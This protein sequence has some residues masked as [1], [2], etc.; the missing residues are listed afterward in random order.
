[1]T[2][3]QLL[4]SREPPP[5]HLSLI[6]GDYRPEGTL[7]HSCPHGT[8][9]SGIHPVRDSGVE[10]DNCNVLRVS[11]VPRGLTGRA[12]VSVDGSLRH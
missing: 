4:V 2:K 11:R 9:L 7:S 5:R 3:I 12:Q 6:V 1:M 8:V 10:K